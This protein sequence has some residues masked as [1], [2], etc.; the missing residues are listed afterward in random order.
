MEPTFPFL[1]LPGEI[2]NDIYRL[3]LSPK[4]VGL[5]SI[6]CRQAPENHGHTERQ[7][8]WYNFQPSILRTNRQT[9]N[10]ASAIFRSENIFIIIRFQA[11]HLPHAFAPAMTLPT[12]GQM[13]QQVAATITLRSTNAEAADHPFVERLYALQDLESTI[14]YDLMAYQCW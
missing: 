14:P 12:C 6:A 10:E 4:H 3:L 5:K 13:Y 11:S 7:K 9:Y 2:R 8:Q 1:K